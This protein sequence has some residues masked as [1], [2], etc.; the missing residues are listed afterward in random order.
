MDAVA[1]DQ[2]ISDAVAG[3][4]LLDHP[5]YRR[6]EAGALLD[7]ELAGY[8]AQ[9]RHFEA[10][11]PGFLAAVAGSLPPGGARRAVEANLHDELGD[12]VAHLEL[13]D[14]FA[15]ALGA[16]RTEATPAAV[17]LVHA[18]EDLAAAGP[19]PALAG[20]AAYEHQAPAIATTKAVGLRV[21]YRLDAGAVTFWDHHATADVAHARWTTEALEH[22]DADPEEVRTC[23]R[24][25]ADA[26]WRFLDER[27]AMRP[28]A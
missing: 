28:A 3:R 17:A 11:L 7:G 24:V 9:Y 2:A 23:A 25:V 20:L 19:V 5:F 21:H 6:W 15:A 18:Y 13:F 16:G 22:L 27:E 12:P 26:W 10:M 4:R 1:I 8:A 14:R